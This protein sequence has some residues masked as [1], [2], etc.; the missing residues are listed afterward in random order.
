MLYVDKNGRKIT[1]HEIAT[2][3][4]QEIELRGIRE[5]EQD[6]DKQLFELKDE[7]LT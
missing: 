5:F 4:P 7:M 2:L 3:S 6:Q 1:K